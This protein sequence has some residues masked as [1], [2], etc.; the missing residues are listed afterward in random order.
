M[1][2]LVLEDAN[3]KTSNTLAHA[4][5]EFS[6]VRTGRANP[7]LIERLTV[8]AYGVDNRLQEIAGFA[9]PEAR[10]LL[11]TP[12]D[13]QN[14]ESI[15][16]AIQNAGLGLNPSNDGRTI[17]LN[18]P[19]LTEERRNELVKVVNNM[20]EDAR[21]RLRGIRRDARKDFD[22]VER[23]GGVSEDEIARAEGQLDDLIHKRE[24]EIES[25]R[26]AKEHELREI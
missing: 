17:R 7:A 20:A 26:E 2:E 13:P 1:I 16:K 3:D 5:T 15:E 9:V 24:A 8:E 18:F 4:R 25:A 12:F 19:P 14:L 6:G 11:V 10:Q 23:D 21:N 22:G